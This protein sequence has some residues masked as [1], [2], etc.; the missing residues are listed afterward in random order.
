[1][2]ANILLQISKLLFLI[3]P[4]STS[5][6]SVG[7]LIR[8]KNGNKCRAALIE[9]KYGDGCLGAERRIAHTSKRLR[10]IH[11]QQETITSLLCCRPWRPSSTNWTNWDCWISTRESATPKV[12]L[13]PE[14]K[15]EVI[16]VLA[17][18]NPRSARTKRDRYVTTLNSDKYDQTPATI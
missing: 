14:N 15:P 2:K 13:D 4:A 3:L 17:N 1:M 5:L 11:L 10:R 18:H 12:K 16:F 6:P 7:W 8:R 9:M